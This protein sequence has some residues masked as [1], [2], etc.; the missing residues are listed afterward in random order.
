[1]M[2]RNNISETELKVW[3]YHH[4]LVCHYVH[5]INRSFGPIILVA[6]C[7]EFMIFI[8]TFYELVIAVQQSNNL[9]AVSI[10]GAMVAR[11]LFFLPTL[12]WTSYTIQLEVILGNI[13]IA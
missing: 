7:H 9:F 1:M 4:N 5:M 6:I 11:E 8:T 13:N 10:Y 12:I 3:K 2:T